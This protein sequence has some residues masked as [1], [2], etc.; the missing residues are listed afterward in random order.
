MMFET[1]EL[2]TRRYTV[3]QFSSSLFQVSWLFIFFQFLFMVW[4]FD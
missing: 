2:G 1:E 4:W 3:A